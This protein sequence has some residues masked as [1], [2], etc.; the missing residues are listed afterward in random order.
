MR[1]VGDEVDEEKGQDNAGQSPQFTPV[2]SQR[3]DHFPKNTPEV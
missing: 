2:A 3:L 1:Y